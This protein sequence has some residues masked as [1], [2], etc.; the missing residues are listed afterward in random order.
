MHAVANHKYDT[1]VQALK[2]TQGQDYTPTQEDLDTIRDQVFKEV[3]LTMHLAAQPLEKQDKAVFLHQQNAATMAENYMRSEAI[4]KLG[5]ARSVYLRKLNEEMGKKPIKNK[6]PLARAKATLAAYGTLSKISLSTQ[7]LAAVLACLTDNAPD[8]D[9]EFEAWL[10]SQFI[11][12]ITGFGLLTLIP[13]VGDAVGVAGRE[14]FGQYGAFATWRDTGMGIS[15]RDLRSIAKLMDEDKD[16][17]ST[18]E[19]V[20]I[21]ANLLRT[22]GTLVGT[23]GGSSKTA[24]ITSE[25]LV[26][27]NTLLN[28]ARPFL[29]R[30]KNT[31]DK[32]TKRAKAYKKWQAQQQR[33]L[34][35]LLK[36]MK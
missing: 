3:S 2:E 33:E 12:G 7:A 9:D 36:Q 1:L 11:A 14:A 19:G 21:S 25:V 30:A 18:S 27:I 29:V 13:F 4:I 6:K 10:W 34:Q 32:E 22:F 17:N 35:K 26:A 31:A 15:D 5:L 24:T 20:L 8:D 23:L 28:T 16:L